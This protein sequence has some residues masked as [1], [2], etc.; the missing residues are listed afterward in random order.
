MALGDFCI[1][2]PPVQLCKA[3]MR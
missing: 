3:W 2:A 1:D